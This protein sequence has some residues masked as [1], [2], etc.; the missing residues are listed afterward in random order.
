MIAFLAL[1]CVP[2]ITSVPSTT[3]ETATPTSE[4]CPLQG[5]VVYGTCVLAMP[6]EDYCSAFG[7]G[8]LDTYVDGWCGSTYDTGTYHSWG[9][10]WTLERCTD[11]TSTWSV[12]GHRRWEDGDAYWKDGG[13]WAADGT[14]IEWYSYS[15]GDCGGSI[16]C[17]GSETSS[18]DVLV[19]TPLP[20]TVTC[21]TPQR[22]EVCR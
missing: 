10:R 14:I 17:C 18:G 9:E 20:E 11:G 5:E 1:G 2:T 4:T 15:C 3:P 16:T 22:E 19:G 21:E 8:V 6:I 13:V 12:A 7:C